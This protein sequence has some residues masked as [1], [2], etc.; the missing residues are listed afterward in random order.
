MLPLTEGGSMSLNTSRIATSSALAVVLFGSGSVTPAS[1]DCVFKGA[2]TA[3]IVLPQS[4]TDRVGYEPLLVSA[5]NDRRVGD[6]IVGFWRTKL[7]AEGNADVADG[8]VIDEG[9]SQWHS[10]GNEMI[11]SLFAPATGNICLGVWERVGSA[12]YTLN[13]F[14]FAFDADGVFLGLAQI[15]E[16][17]VLDRRGHRFGGT[18]TFEQYDLAGAMVAR[19]TGRVTATRITVHTTIQEVL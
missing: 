8:T 9:F 11:V 3:A 19:L 15:R 5:A 2:P 12:S 1:G 13:H 18:F 14:G 6:G 16:H 4:G 17:V 10:D 7:V